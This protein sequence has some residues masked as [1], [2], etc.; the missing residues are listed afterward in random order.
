MT[1]ID[2][3]DATETPL[4]V[5]TFADALPTDARIAEVRARLEDA[6]VKYVMAC[7]IDLFGIPKTKPVPMSDFE[8]L[9]K[10][11]GPQFAVHSVSFVPEL[12]P[13]DS[14]Q[15]VVPDLN[16][17]YVCP[18]DPTI[19]IIFS[20]LFWEDKPYNVCPRQA[21]KRAIAEAARQGYRGYAG[22]EPEFIVMRY[23]EHGR[24][25][26]AFDTDPQQPGALRPRR[27]AYGY[28]TEH[29]LDAMP[30]LKDLIDMLEGLGWGLNDVV[31]EGAYSQFE[32]DFGYSH[33]LQ[34]ADR[35]V[36]LRLTLKEVA[37]KHGMFV[38][39]MPKPTTG[40]WRSGAHINFSLRS[41]ADP[42]RNLFEDGDG[43]WS[44]ECRHAVGGLIKHS[45][46]LT[47]ITC[48]TVNSYNGLVPRVG[49]FEGGTVTWAPTNITYGHNNRSAQFRL[50]QN[51]FCIENRAADMCMNIYLALAATLAAA[52]EGVEQAIDPGE[53]SD[54]DLYALSEE[55]AERMGIRRLPRNLYEAI[56]ALKQDELFRHVLGEQMV[57]SYIAY[58][59]DEWERYHQ[60]VTDWEVN[61]Y[62]RLY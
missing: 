4:Y 57:K 21:L 27:Q 51:R 12:T 48:S 46:A 60:A 19:A 50:P 22:I 55:E 26:K 34:M 49:G 13:A 30:F 7:W 43:G 24:P 16:A 61:E 62:L 40:D 20:D 56:K 47:A 31:A 6:G 2:A 5:E 45:E 44:T 35:F 38:T 54:F 53:P 18:W 3:S 15:V 11:R 23:D 52:V 37:K 10:G 29:S 36:F 33:L 58:K 41:L 42:D 59:V 32:L 8:A 17:V 25:V 39:F 1:V 28:D 14:D 9:C